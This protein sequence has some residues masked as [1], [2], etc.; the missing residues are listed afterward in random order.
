MMPHRE[1][2]DFWVDAYTIESFDPKIINDRLHIEVGRT[3][4][5]V[6]M[7]SLVVISCHELGMTRKQFEF[8]AEALSVRFKQLTQELHHFIVKRLEAEK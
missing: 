3:I 7:Q 4:N 8:L 1:R 2:P 5:G 6:K